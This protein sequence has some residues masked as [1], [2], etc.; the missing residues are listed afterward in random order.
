MG[1]TSTISRAVVEATFDDRVWAAA[2]NDLGPERTVTILKQ[3]YKD[4]GLQVQQRAASMANTRDSD[5]VDDDEYRA[6]KADY[7]DWLRR[8]TTIRRRV[9]ARLSETQPLAQSIH[10]RH[11]ADRRVVLRLAKRVWLWER[12]EDHHLETALDDLDCSLG[13]RGR[14]PLR[15]VVDALAAGANGE[16]L[17]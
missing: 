2:V 4:I 5:D 3:V 6:A 13:D 1:P 9:S 10:D 11:Q 8:A 12:G 7:N 17:P 15:E 14:R 16:V